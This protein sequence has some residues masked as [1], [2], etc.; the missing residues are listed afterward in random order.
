MTLKNKNF[1]TLP[2]VYKP[3]F[4]ITSRAS[5]DTAISDNSML[6]KQL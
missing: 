5:F 6:V 4:D 2:S 1:L 3:I